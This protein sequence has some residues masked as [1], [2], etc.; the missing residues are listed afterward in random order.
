M[1]KRGKIITNGIALETHEFLTILYFT[2]LGYNVEILPK[3]NI[4]GQHTPDVKINGIKWEMKS[5]KGE[6][7]SLIKNTI[8]KALKQSQYII[9]DLRRTKRNQQKCIRE[10]ENHFSHSKSI[11][12][13]LAIT[14]DSKLL[15]Y[16]K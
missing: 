7:N 5:P 12:R 2:E 1:S 8:Q 16:K 9:I 4:K 10:I 15:D 11:K 13:I 3:S 14:K 6:G